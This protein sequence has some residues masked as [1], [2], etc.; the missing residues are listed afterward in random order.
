MTL[1]REVFHMKAGDIKKTL[2]LLTLWSF[3]TATLAIR[4]LPIMAQQQTFPIP[5]VAVSAT[6]TE[7]DLFDT[8]GEVG[9]ITTEELEHIQAQSLD[10]ALWYQPGVEM[11][12]GPRRI[13]EEPVIRG[14]DGQRVL[15]TIDGARLNFESGHKGRG[16]Q[17]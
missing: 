12:G 2:A 11:S 14:L 15:M 13:G 5:G 4:P 6:K 17:G 9:V 1:K 16:L 7:R 8:P 3:V 10:D